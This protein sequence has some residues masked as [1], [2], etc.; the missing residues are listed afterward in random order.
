[1]GKLK[2]Y[3]SST[4]LDLVPVRKIILDKINKD[5]NE[6]FEFTEIMEN[7]R[8]ADGQNRPDID[9]CLSNVRKADVYI[10]LL[11][12]RYGSFPA[13]YT[14]SKGKVIENKDARSY[15]QLEY[16]AACERVD[17]KKYHIYKIELTD[18][19]FAQAGFDQ[20]S[21]LIDPAAATKFE[22]FKTLLSLTASPNQVSSLND[23]I[24]INS[25]LTKSKLIFDKISQLRITD[26][27]KISINRTQQVSTLT[28]NINTFGQDARV[29]T[30]VINTKNQEDDATDLFSKKIRTI[31]RPAEITEI[32]RNIT[33]VDINA[34]ADSKINNEEEMLNKILVASSANI[35]GAKASFIDFESLYEEIKEQKIQNRFLGFLID[36]R[37][38]DSSTN[39]YIKGIRNFIHKIESVLKTNKFRYNFFPIIY[40]IADTKQT[41][42]FMSTHMP[43]FELQHIELGVLS[44]IELTDIDK[45][46]DAVAESNDDEFKEDFTANKDQ[47]LGQIFGD[48]ESFPKSYRKCLANINSRTKSI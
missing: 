31:L 46:L 47:I 1:M 24:V 30:L 6:D 29:A 25:L 4:Y 10:I 39:D 15:T 45:W 22:K 48:K 28:S 5:L 44:D 36:L 41:E 14:D 13:Q 11:G 35:L 17:V 8:L 42:S 12:K 20:Q 3:I 34:L 21:D 23:L 40:V 43:D 32:A 38:E 33:W 37:I 2:V 26:E 19:F 27:S 16:E 7:M 9:I 18:A